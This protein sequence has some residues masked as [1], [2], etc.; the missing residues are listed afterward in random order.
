[1]WTVDMADSEKTAKPILEEASTLAERVEAIKAALAEG[2]SLQEV[3]DI[4]DRLD[5]VSAG[6]GDSHD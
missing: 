4:L 1:M 6:R 3:E 2:L 5:N